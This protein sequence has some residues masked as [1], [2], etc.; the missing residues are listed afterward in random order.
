MNEKNPQSLVGREYT[1][2]DG[3]RIRVIE[4]KERDSGPWVTYLAIR[5]NCLEQKLIM[6]YS[7]FM[8]QYSHLFP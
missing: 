6:S 4:V 5:P 8:G 7:E 3:N 1:W 2:E